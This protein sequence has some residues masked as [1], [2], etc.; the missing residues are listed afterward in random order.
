MKEAVAPPSYFGY[1]FPPELI[2]HAVWRYFR[3]ALGYRD[4][5]EMLAERGV[6]LTDET[7]RQWCR[8]FG[9]TDA[10]AL[11][12]RRPRPGDTWHLDEVFIRLHGEQHYLWRAVDQDGHVLDIL[13]Q[14][15]RDKA[16]AKKFFRRL[17]KDLAY[18]PRVAIIDKL[19]SYG[20]ALREVLPS[21]EHRR[22]K[23]LNNRAENSHQ[24]TRERERRMRRFKDPGHAQRFLAAYGPIASHFRPRR[25]RLTAEAYR[26][27]R[28]ERF[29]TWRA[30]TGS[31]AIA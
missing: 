2:G 12:R 19:A 15:R 17:L 6:I 4:V 24:P 1:R 18:V 20:A 3:F 21:V 23:G 31:P 11:R 25:H 26:E 13:V 14:R 8:K 29:A 5:E 27:T 7:V 22:H 10:N 30:V 28:T 9:Q 16:A